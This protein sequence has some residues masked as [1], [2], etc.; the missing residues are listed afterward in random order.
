MMIVI[1]VS[2]LTVNGETK[3]GVAACENSAPANPHGRERIT[4]F[5]AMFGPRVWKLPLNIIGL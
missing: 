4:S 2:N 1:T 3:H 5:V